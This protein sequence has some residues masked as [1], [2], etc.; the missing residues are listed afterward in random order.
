[1]HTEPL[2]A[3]TRAAPAFYARGMS[4]FVGSKL[5]RPEGPAKV[6]GSALYIADLEVEG[7]WYGGVVRSSLAHGKLL[8]IDFE[9][10]FDTSRVALVTAS[11]IPG[12]NVVQLLVDD[13]PVLVE[14]DI[15]HVGEPL[16]LVAAPTRAL[17]SEALS[18]ARPK[19]EALEPVLDMRDSQVIFKAQDIIKGDVDAVFAS[20]AR[21][22]E[23][24]YTTDSQEQLYIETQGMI[25]WPADENGQVVVRGSLQCPHYVQAALVRALAL[26]PEQARVI[27]MET[28][29][30]FGGKEDYPSV[31]AC[32]VAL[33][34]RA[35]GQPVELIFDRHEDLLV[36]PKRHPS[37]VKHRTAVDAD[38][39]LLAM[40]I[41][42]LFDGGAY[43]TLSPVVISRGVI[44]AA[45]AY[46][47][48]NVRVRGRVVKTNH[49]PYGAYRGFGAPQVCF[50]VERHMDRI[51]RELGIHPVALR[52]TNM[53]RLGDS[54]ATGHVLTSSI[55][56]EE[57]MRRILEHTGFDK[58]AWGSPKNGR[59]RRGTGLSFFFHGA[60]FTGSGEERLKG[61]VELELTDEGQVIVRT[62]STEIGQG[63]NTM[64]V[65][66][67]AD[68]LDAELDD[69]CLAPVDTG[70]VPDSGP[71]V[72]SRTVM[73]V[74]GCVQ[75]ACAQLLERLGEG[76]GKFRTRARNF[77]AAGG[78]RAV[79]VTYSSPPGLKWDE[80]TYRGDA[81]PT[82]GWAADVV[83][84]AVDLDT[85]EVDIEH[86][87]S[88]VDV[89]KAIQPML[90][91]GQIEGGS[92]QAL[93]FAHREVV[94]SKDGRVQQDRLATCV[95]PT[96]LDAPTMDILLVEEPFAQGPFG[97]KGVGEL[98]M[99]GGAPAFLAAIE[100]A[101]GIVL[102]AVPATPER[103]LAAWLELHPEE[104]LV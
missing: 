5:R 37:L 16:A 95:I 88:A 72:A 100:D 4:K 25:G 26:R 71:T 43:T 23:G 6:Q 2:Q 31:L 30:G 62:G 61:R 82:Y 1:M 54:T 13:Q 51:A 101:T 98:P 81:Y 75:R 60:G 11:D 93:G 92:L 79:S 80:E 74:G 90:V 85:F 86:F 59:I 48:D 44:H 3:W 65:A 53:L 33:L 8:G 40:D 73:I 24:S 84:V 28:G 57:V 41:E 96:A 47:C 39:K 97:A 99:D 38:G 7:V 63:T 14:R 34:A 19:I 104:R 17:L 66:V 52:K 21:V 70:L 50:A 103:L 55:A 67:T 89:G 45:G 49:V 77:V 69:I 64:F 46:G 56:T 91:E 9:A 29:G 58:H 87:V 68:A 18:A 22:F 20:D 35:C 36:T 42:V 78:E 15:E 76:P 32:H 83:Q 12:D 102:D 27:Q 94:T 10:G